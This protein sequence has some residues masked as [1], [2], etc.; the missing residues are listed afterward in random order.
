MKETRKQLQMRGI[1]PGRGRSSTGS[2]GPPFPQLH[3]CKSL[4]VWECAL[5]QRAGSAGIDVHGQPFAH[6]SPA[7]N[8]FRV[9]WSSSVL[10]GFSGL[11][12]SAC[13]AARCACACSL[14][15]RD[16]G[17]WKILSFF[18]FFFFFFPCFPLQEEGPGLPLFPTGSFSWSSLSDKPLLR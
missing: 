5:P 18:L 6:Q 8:G 12:Q 17:D 13:A 7:S 4:L 1:L 15:F 9:P 10:R 3:G 11:Q 14:G 2:P 16:R